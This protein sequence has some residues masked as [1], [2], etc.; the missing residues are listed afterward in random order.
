MSTP[1]VIE[2][3]R[4]DA[5]AFHEREPECT[6]A[7][8]SFEVDRPTLVLG[9]AQPADSV[10]RRVADALDVQV[11]RRRSGGGG[12]LLIPHEFVWLD[13]VVPV[14]D[15]LWHDDIGLATHWV[16]ELWQQV[17]ADAGI[18]S[19]VHRGALVSSPW[20]RQVCFAGLGPGEVVAAHRKLV[21]ISQR[22]TRSW[23][24]LQT[25]CHLRWRPELVAALV[26]YHAPA[27]SEIGSIVGCIDVEAVDLLDALITR[28]AER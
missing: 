21:G 22:R 13:V 7:A 18:A 11:V 4:G 12:V 28:L 9:S 8:W 1:W 14:G 17:L 6:R 20:S 19:T 26:A 5:A 2:Q 10:N 25:M 16:G 23:L 15:T 24:R 3:H 27:A